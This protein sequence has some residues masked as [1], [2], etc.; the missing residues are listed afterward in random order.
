MSGIAGIYHRDGRP[1][2]TAVLDQMVGR[3]S[4]RGPDGRGCWVNGRVAL[5]HVM[6][7]STPE[8][9]YER[10]PLTDRTGHLALT[11]DGRV[12]NRDELRVE[13]AS[14]GLLLRDDTDAE[15]VLAAYECWGET[16]PLHLIG[17]FAFAIWDERR[18]RLFCA[19]DHIGIRP[20]YYYADDRRFLFASEL[21]SLLIH[22]AVPCEPNE[23][24]IGEFLAGEITSQAETLYQVIFRLPPAHSLVLAENRLTVRRYWNLD[25]QRELR[26]GNDEAYAEHF[27]TLFREAVRCRLR[28]QGPVGSYLS[29]GLDSSSV[30]GMAQ[31]LRLDG[32]AEGQEFETFSLVFPGFPCDESAYIRDMVQMWNIPSTRVRPER[33]HRAYF[34]DLAQQ[35][36]DFPGY[37]NGTM[38]HPLRALAQEKGIR[39]LLTGGGGDEWL[40]GSFYHAADLLRGWRILPAIRRV[41][42]D[43]GIS[44]PHEIARTAVECGIRPL[45]PHALRRTL[46]RMLGRDGVPSWIAPQFARRIHLAERLAAVSNVSR[47]ANFAQKDIHGTL[48]SGWWIHSNEIEERAAFRCGI[49]ERHPLCDRRIVE[50]ALALP[51]EQRWR[52]IETKCILR[53][54]MRGLLPESVRRRSTKAEFSLVFSEAFQ[55]LGGPRFFQRLPS[56]SMGWVDKE[57]VLAMYRQMV[58]RET[59]DGSTPPPQGWPL[60]MVAGI[61]L[62]WGTMSVRR[63]AST[64][65]ALSLAEATVQA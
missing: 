32:L 24:M 6:L 2:E 60:W 40:A 55:A 59:P 42:P 29:G 35:D 50:F 51:E 9:R 38:G 8:S 26:Y 37:P 5:G 56:A 65:A 45:V 21:A 17:D 15:L 46:K 39:V 28:S 64:P 12:D 31:S 3:L 20:F 18:Q 63:P 62:W 22:P 58:E 13:L 10:Q 30:V 48:T 23:G 27:R 57:L 4:H 36:L 41:G 53:R 43:A 25:L 61:D 54:A 52:G 1:I 11:L 7:H 34:A 33:Q 49:E 16:A 14:K 47:F 19:R 44:D